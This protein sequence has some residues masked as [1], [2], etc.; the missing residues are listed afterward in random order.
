MERA[1]VVSFN[2]NQ[3]GVESLHRQADLQ[4][5]QSFFRHRP[6][7][8]YLS[9][10]DGRINGSN[11]RPWRCRFRISHMPSFFS[12]ESW[13]CFRRRPYLITCATVLRPK[14]RGLFESWQKTML[15]RTA[16]T[17]KMSP[18]VGVHL[19]KSSFGN[20]ELRASYNV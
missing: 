12:N 14:I 6:A 8:L 7:R 19:R 15:N 4:I 10:A 16:A 11:S 2:L 20:L 3:A 18:F 1:T 13:M 5:T 17:A 9:I